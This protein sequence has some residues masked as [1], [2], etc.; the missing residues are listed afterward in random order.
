MAKIPDY[1]T[2]DLL[3]KITVKIT[4]KHTLSTTVR[5]WIGSKIIILGCMVMGVDFNIIT[6]RTDGGG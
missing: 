2:K 5:M 3:S 6:I 1:N 4:I